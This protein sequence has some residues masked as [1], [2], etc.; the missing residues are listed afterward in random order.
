MLQRIH[1]R[2]HGWFAWL[3][4]MVIGVT[5]TLFGASYYIG[6]RGATEVKATVGESVI[7]KGEFDI[8]YR[9]LKHQEKILTTTIEQR[10]K[11]QTMKQLIFNHVVLQAA[12]QEG[13]VVSKEQAQR[14]M[15]GIPQFYED[16]KFSQ[17]RFQQALSSNLFTPESFL[18]QVTDGMLI[19]QQRFMFSGSSFVLPSESKRFISLAMQKRDYRY[20]TINPSDFKVDLSV[21]ESE[22]TSYYNA[23]QATF[24]LPEKVSI[25]YV[26]LSMKGLM[27]TLSFS[28]KAIKTYYQENKSNYITPARYKLQHILVSL[29]NKDRLKVIDDALK[30]GTPFKE[31]ATRYS[32]DLLS[33][34]A[35]LPWMT[36]GMLGT[37]V[38]KTLVTLKKGNVS[39]PIETKKGYEILKLVEKK[40]I[41]TLPFE[42]V[43]EAIQKTLLREKAQRLF[44]QKNDELADLSY[45]NPDSLTTTANTLGLKVLSTPL[46]TKKGLSSGLASNTAIVS[47]AY[48]PEVLTQG[49]NSQPIQLNEDSVVVLRVKEHKVASVEPFKQAKIRVMTLLKDIKAQQKSDAL[50]VTLLTALKEKLPVLEILKTNHLQWKK[51]KNITRQQSTVPVDVN[52]LAFDVRVSSDASKPSIVGK[53][54]NGRFVIV[55]LIKTMPGD[56]ASL[57]KAEQKTIREQLESNY[58]IRDYD[59]YLKSLMANANVDIKSE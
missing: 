26:Q 15:M 40:D 19:N 52:E 28:D 25:E 14:A 58:G 34:N 7:T 53:Q 35:E 16:G 6:S 37:N 11:Q 38:D 21:S 32:I 1:E 56:M 55:D 20:L 24:M 23:H 2:V 22:A 5:F 47:T 59:V 9:R 4:I 54:V 12:K 41:K 30:K 13:F 18:S 17:E 36:V 46:F 8:A 33:P 3:I 48:S 29:E 57:S 51:V 49:E 39:A 31:V 10:L 27:S 50:G 42:Q 45:Q 44:V 43:K